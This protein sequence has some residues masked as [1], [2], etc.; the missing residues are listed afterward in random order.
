VKA[1][2]TGDEGANKILYSDVDL[3]SLTEYKALIVRSGY[4]NQLS[5]PTASITALQDPSIPGT[6]VTY[7]KTISIPKGY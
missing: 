1:I 6:P 7:S 3:T 5:V 4:R 2:Y